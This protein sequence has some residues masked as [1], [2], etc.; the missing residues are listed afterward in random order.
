MP[1]STAFGVTNESFTQEFF[2]D[3]LQHE[4]PAVFVLLDAVN[5]RNARIIQGSQHL[6]FTLK[7]RYPLGI[8]G[9]CLGQYLDRDFAL[10]LQVPRPVDL[11]HAPR[12]Q[13]T[14]DFVISKSHDGSKGCPRLLRWCIGGLYANW[15]DNC[16]LCR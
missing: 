11:A 10:E 15:R 13:R 5:R 7:P 8:T 12:A 4:K 1:R 9:K 2:D 16:F 3:K 14:D 6:G